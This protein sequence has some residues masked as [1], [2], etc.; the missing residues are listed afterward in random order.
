MKSLKITLRFSDGAFHSVDRAIS[1][2][3]SLER[4]ELLDIDLFKDDSCVLFYRLSGHNLD[5]LQRILDEHPDIISGEA[6]THENHHYLFMHIKEGEPIST[7]MNIVDKHA[8]LLRRPLLFTRKGSLQVE[9][10]GTES[11]LRDALDEALR[12]V[13]VEIDKFTEYIPDRTEGILS[14]LTERQLEV[15]RSAVQL[16]YFENPR[17]ASYE[18]IAEE[19]NCSTTTANVL[20]REA[21]R[22]VFTSLFQSVCPSSS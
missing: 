4:R 6:L 17:Q 16:G 21:E 9:V 8:L 13:D 20:L 7:L 10:I 5:Q 18:E 2:V 15:L 3:E 19:V 12:E 11:D 1:Q 14:I 22:K